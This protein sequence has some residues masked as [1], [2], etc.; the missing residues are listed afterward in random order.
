M[1][2]RHGYGKVVTEGLV[3]ALDA[4]DVNSYPGS[5]TTWRDLSGNGNDGTL[6]NGP[7]FSSN[8]GG[9]LDFDGTNDHVTM[10]DILSLTSFTLEIWFKGTASDI[11]PGLLT[12]TDGSNF[13]NYGFYGDIND[14]YVRFGFYS[15]GSQKEV[16]DSSYE[17]LQAEEWVHYMGSYAGNGLK[18]YRNGILIA[19]D[20]ATSTP[21]TNNGELLIGSRYNLN[22]NFGGSIATAK[23]YNRA[24]TAS[25][26]RINYRHYKNRFNI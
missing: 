22:Y 14:L 24:L 2:V 20:S 12:K 4:A 9:S 17:D 26:V 7:T 13:G 8:N 19:S 5:G 10:G 15:N 6:T 25:E 3:F 16:F 23:I 21:S 1:A 18:L 11:Y